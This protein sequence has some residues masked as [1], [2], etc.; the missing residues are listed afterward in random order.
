MRLLRLSERKRRTCKTISWRIYGAVQ[1]RGIHQCQSVCK[2][3]IPSIILF[4]HVRLFVYS[5]NHVQHG[6]TNAS[7]A[8]GNDFGN[9]IFNNTVAVERNFESV[10]VFLIA[11]KAVLENVIH[12]QIC[13]SISHLL[14]LNRELNV[15]GFIAL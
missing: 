11:K 14:S 6:C 7:E 8:Y 3:V 9:S 12:T 5:Y 15:G 13:E 4:F 2:I 10:F 1:L